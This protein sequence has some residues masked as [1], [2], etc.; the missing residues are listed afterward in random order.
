M[1]VFLS[2]S[3]GE[4][5]YAAHFASILNRLVGAEAYIPKRTAAGENMAEKI[6]NRIDKCKCMVAIITANTQN[7]VWQNQEIG[8]ATAKK[9]P[10]IPIKEEGVTNK[11]FLEGR[12]YII[13]KPNDLDL[14]TY[15]LLA[16]IREILHGLEVRIKCSSCNHEFHIFLPNPQSI[17]NA[18][19]NNL[20]FSPAC[21]GCY[22]KVLVEPKTLT[23]I[24]SHN[25]AELVANNKY[26]QTEFGFG[27]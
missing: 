22:R 12:G 8:Y 14:N 7:D 26:R 9:K 17:N 19:K 11:G 13:L 21:P 1:P 3:I 23:T 6:K 18:I 2:Y 27:Y 15:E 4:G 20:V 25:N 5:R 16:R 10:I 24:R